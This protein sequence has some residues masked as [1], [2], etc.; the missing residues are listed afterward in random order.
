MPI[1]DALRL[2]LAALVFSAGLVGC[3]PRADIEAPLA[4]TEAPGE[5]LAR[6]QVEEGASRALSPHFFGMNTNVTGY[7]APWSRPELVQAV[8]D[9]GLATVRYPAGSIGNVWDWDIGWIAQDVP[10][11]DMV[12]FIVK[13]RIQDSPNRYTLENVAKLHRETGVEVVFML[14]MLTR[15]LEHSRRGL[16]RAD[17]LGIPVRYVE[18][19][20]EYYFDLPLERRVFPTPESYGETSERWIRVL[21]QDFPEAEFAVLGGGPRRHPRQERWDERVIETAPSAEAMTYHFYMSSGLRGREKALAVSQEGQVEADLTRTPAQVQAAVM[22]SLRSRS[23]VQR[24]LMQGFDKGSE[25]R[26]KALTAGGRMWITEFN[27]NGSDDAARGTWANALFLA[28]L[29]HSYLDLDEVELVQYHNIIGRVF[30]AV[31]TNADGFDHVLDN[32]PVSTPGE[33]T[34]T[35]VATRLFTQ[36]VAGHRQAVRLRF[37]NAPMLEADGQRRPALIG[38]TFQGGDA[39]ARTLVFNLSDAPVALGGLAAGTGE[40]MSAPADRYIDGLKSTD[41]AP[42]AVGADGRAVLPAFS[43]TTLA[44]AQ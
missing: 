21:R 25:V 28:T 31:F 8:R 19:G 42:L 3:A 10:D 39:P 32:P 34:A 18:M 20:N 22:D 2:P 29:Y 6:V 14:N 38:W 17:S 30:P 41:R 12:P 9:L 27:M 26:E 1:S 33:L 40:A 13:N 24:M 23:G 44:H 37:P 15:D 7:D 16:R 35:G 4:S 36:A 11:E 43:A 5:V